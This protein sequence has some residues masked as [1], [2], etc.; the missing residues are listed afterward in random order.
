MPPT[1]DI[2]TAALVLID[3]QKGTLS[4]PLAPHGA[5]QI[6]ENAAA[7]GRRF[8]EVGATVILTHMT[9]SNTRT[10]KPNHAAAV[11]MLAPPGLSSEWSKLAPAIK[12]LRADVVISKRKWNAFSDTELDWQL[13]RRG[14][15]TIVLGG[16]TTNVGVEFTAREAR[17]HNYAV[18]V[19]ED[20]VTSVDADFHKFAVEKILPRIAWVRSTK[21]ILRPW[22]LDPRLLPS[23]QC[24]QRTDR[25]EGGAHGECSVEAVEKGRLQRPGRRATQVGTMRLEGEQGSTGG[26]TQTEEDGPGHSHA[27]SLP[28]D[29]RG[30]Q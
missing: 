10:D 25:R 22:T 6:V 23:N 16:I 11:S 1:L 30:G 21:E 8:G 3:I 4:R 17:R 29:P 5:A 27:E 9:F 7:L 20:A 14:I 28:R 13:R 2:R 18:I 19:A 26:P 24:R 15:T 12:S